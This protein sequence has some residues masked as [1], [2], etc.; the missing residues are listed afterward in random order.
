MIHETGADS[1][2]N[3]GSDSEFVRSDFG[4]IYKG[5][6][7]RTPRVEG[8]GGRGKKKQGE[9]EHQVLPHPPH[10]CGEQQI[11]GVGGGFWVVFVLFAVFHS[12]MAFF[13]IR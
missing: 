9:K 12:L 2:R 5:G 11:V 10:I 4:L 6:K 8:I 1:L 7:H 13:S 3:K